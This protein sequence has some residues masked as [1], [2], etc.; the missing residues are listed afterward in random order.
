M[1]VTGTRLPAA[2]NLG[3]YFR[4]TAIWDTTTKQQPALALNR[5]ALMATSSLE[6]ILWVTIP[7]T[8]ISSQQ[9]SHRWG[10]RACHVN[11]FPRSA[12][13]LHVCRMPTIQQ[14]WCKSPSGFCLILSYGHA[15]DLSHVEIPSTAAMLTFTISRLSTAAQGLT[16]LL[17]KPDK[18]GRLRLGKVQEYELFEPF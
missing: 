8:S 11:N 6:V 3:N 15:R 12:R 4:L 14:A 7:N 18:E 10:S 2:V 13:R 17:S 1:N 5:T 16:T 9:G